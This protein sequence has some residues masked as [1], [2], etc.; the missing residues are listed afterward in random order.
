MTDLQSP[1]TKNKIIKI[2][3]YQ[4][5]LTSDHLDQMDGQFH[6][7]RL[8]PISFFFEYRRI[9]FKCSC[10]H[11]TSDGLPILTLAAKLG[12]IPFTAQSA[13]GRRAALT[14]VKAA[15]AHLKGAITL[16]KDIIVFKHSQP[17]ET[18]VTSTILVSGIVTSIHQLDPYLNLLGEVIGLPRRTPPPTSPPKG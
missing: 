3:K 7:I 13:L 2:G 1:E 8:D 9:K 15:H 5:P 16:H 6:D 11:K 4:L 14:I 10:H 17:V 18:P 12:A